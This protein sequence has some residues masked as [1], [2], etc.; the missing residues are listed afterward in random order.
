[1]GV[2]QQKCNISL[3]TFWEVIIKQINY[4]HEIFQSG[5]SDNSTE[6]INFSNQQKTSIKWFLCVEEETST[7]FVHSYVA[8]LLQLP[9]WLPLWLPVCMALWLSVLKII[10]CPHTY[11]L[12]TQCQNIQFLHTHCLHTHCLH[13]HCLHTHFLHTYCLHKNCLIHIVYIWKYW[14]SNR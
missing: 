11:Y 3:I 9:L 7:K 6:I 12:W 8:V 4:I 1:M 5:G 13:T 10:Y 2:E 14:F